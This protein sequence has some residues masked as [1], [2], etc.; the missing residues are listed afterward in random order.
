ME[1]LQELERR[2]CYEF[3]NKLLLIEALTHP[4][5]SKYA[6]IKYSY[7]RLEFLGNSILGA[8]LADIIYNK[9][10]ECD[11]GYLSIV[12]SKMAST[13]GIIV[14]MKELNIE[15]YIIIDAGEEKNGGRYNPRN[16]EN[17]IE[18]IIGAIYLDG[19]YEQVKAFISMFWMKELIHKNDLHIRD[20]KSRLQE[21]CHKNKLSIPQYTVLLQEGFVHSPIFTIS[22]LIYIKEQKIESK[23]NGLSKKQAEQNTATLMLKK[24]TTDYSIL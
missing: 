6:D 15:K 16:I 2:I 13:N 5:M 19:S 4:S 18:A 23:A 12:H 10:S 8:V 3:N 24:L 11:E 21:L 22:C 17:C 7:E 1:H 20:P 14:A 9:F